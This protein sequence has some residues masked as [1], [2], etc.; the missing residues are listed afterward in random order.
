MFGQPAPVCGSS[1]PYGNNSAAG[2]YVTVN[3]VKIYYEVYGTGPAL[4]LLHGNGGSIARGGCQIEFFA[5]KR[6]VIAV[7]SRGHGKSDDGPGALTFEQQA[8]DFIAVLDA[9]RVDR[10]DV[11][12]HSDGGILALELGIRHPN[13]VGKIVASGPNL[14]PD[15]TALYESEIANM[16]IGLAQATA[17]L[18]AHD[19]TRDWN[20]Q[21]RQREL[22]LN[23]PHISLD[24][25]RS[26]N[27]EEQLIRQSELFLQT[28][29]RF[30]AF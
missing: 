3:S 30:H 15:A 24:A 28:D 8:D 2:H 26:I 4:L 7:D 11:F 29:R 16:R 23:E 22:D 6:R 25:V 27:R 21:K 12:G 17:K 10:A 20:R 19:T 1:V 9:E 5:P 14:R 18:D 13:R